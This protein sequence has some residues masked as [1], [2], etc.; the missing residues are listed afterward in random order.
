MVR[1]FLF[2]SVLCYSPAMD[3][4]PLSAEEERRA[5]KR[6][7]HRRWREKNRDHWLAR[8]REAARR[9]RANNPEAQAEANS[10][11]YAKNRNQALAYAKA[12]REANPETV[13]KAVRKWRDENPGRCREYSRARDAGLN[14]ATPAWVNR[15]DIRYVYEMA[16]LFGV[17]V[18]HIYP[19]KGKNSCGLHVPWN[20][21]L[22]PAT[23]NIRKGNKMPDLNKEGYF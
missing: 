18:D 19:L 5:R 4:A 9:Y 11:Q 13:R 1:G 16:S 8:S 17:H 23:E 7:N 21:Q 12:Y 14:K 22:L 6:E 15:D 10:K 3:N 20:L 2:V